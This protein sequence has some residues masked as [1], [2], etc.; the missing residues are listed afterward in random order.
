M[1]SVLSSS[2]G[3]PYHTGNEENKKFPVSLAGRAEGRYVQTAHESSNGIPPYDKY[4]SLKAAVADCL[5]EKKFRHPKKKD[6]IEDEMPDKAPVE[7]S[8]T[9]SNKGQV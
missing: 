5:L 7:P 8:S 4:V 3:W 1:A 6:T 2:S 9:W